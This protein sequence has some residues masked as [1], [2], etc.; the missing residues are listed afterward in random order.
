MTGSL[1]K[2]DRCGIGSSDFKGHKEST[3]SDPDRLPVR[4]CPLWLEDEHAR[5]TLLV[6]QLERRNFVGGERDLSGAGAR[7][8]IAFVLMPQWRA[9]AV[10]DFDRV[11]R[12]SF[13]PSVLDGQR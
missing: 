10:A 4:R 12:A 5:P 13:W 1:R 7:N 2:A 3:W 11:P 6:R 9:A 8:P